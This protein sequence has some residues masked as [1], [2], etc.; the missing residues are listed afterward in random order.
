MQEIESFEPS[1]PNLASVSIVFRAQ[2]ENDYIP[3]STLH[4]HQKQV[5]VTTKK[6]NKH[7]YHD[8]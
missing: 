7:N 1:K 2:P 5:I 4:E 3:N 6:Q 8:T